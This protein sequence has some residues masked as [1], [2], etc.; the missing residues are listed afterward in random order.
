MCQEASINYF[1][2]PRGYWNMGLHPCLQGMLCIRIW[3]NVSKKDIL[4][5]KQNIEKKDIKTLLI[6]RKI[7]TSK[8]KKSCDIN[9][10]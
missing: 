1:H 8:S 9:K 6:R 10:F 3:T 2:C 5:N 4:C 7:S